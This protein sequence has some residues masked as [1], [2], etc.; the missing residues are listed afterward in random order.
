MAAIT[1]GLVGASNIAMTWML[2]A[3]QATG[4]AVRGL[5]DSEPRR[6]RYWEEAGVEAQTTDL[7]QLLASEID[8]VYIS[9]RN[10]QHLKHTVAAAEAGK[11]I[12][13]EKPI[14]LTVRDAEL[15][16]DAAQRNN[17]VLAVNHHLVASPLH[18]AARRLVAEGRIGNLVGARVNHAVTLPEHL[19]GWR[20]TTDP[21]AGVIMDITV[22]DASVLNLLFG[23][24]PTEV[25]AFAAAQAAW[26][27]S[28]ALDSA[29][30][31]LRYPSSPSGRERLASTYDSFTVSG[32]PTELEIFG[33]EG[34]ITITDAMTQQTA[35][36][37]SLYAAGAVESV[38]VDTGESLYVTLLQAF[39][40]AIRREGRPLTTGEEGLG[41]LKVALAAEQSAQTRERVRLGDLH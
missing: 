14:A 31:V 5:Y 30:A 34:T 19:R 15:M 41:A 1:F 36:S 25:V 20:M 3:F 17:V 4:I 9:S 21:G 16:I 32:P 23:G 11:H 10:D 29:M 24:E 2:P 33:D 39:L 13:V 35:G 22:H 8:A 37:V 26:N 40:A 18:A 7:D 27:D 6:F 28:G 38:E 12:L